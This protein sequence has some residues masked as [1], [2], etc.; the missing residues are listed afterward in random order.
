MPSIS[1]S[2]I[3]TLLFH[4]MVGIGDRCPVNQPKK[5][6][7]T[8]QMGVLLYVIAQMIII[9]SHLVL[10]LIIQCDMFE[11]NRIK[12]CGL[13][14][15]MIFKNK[16]IET[17]QEHFLLE[18]M[19]SL[20]QKPLPN[21]QKKLLII[22][23]V[24]GM[25]FFHSNLLFCYLQFLKIFRYLFFL[26]RRPEHGPM[27]VQLT[28]PVSRFKHIQ[29]LQHMCR[30]ESRFHHLLNYCFNI[31]FFFPRFVILKT[32]VR[33]DLIGTLPLPRRLLDYLNYKHY[34][35]EQIESD[36]SQSQVSLLF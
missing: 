1:Q 15:S 31:L 25:F 11:S 4:S 27:R 29:S 16:S 23:E 22:P 33:K 20:S 35:S 21:L 8:N 14:F 36:S 24:E 32:V 19:L 13:W 18:V 34:Y 2:K 26:H 17:F 9:F 3:T 6:Y 5:F 7:P 10:S 12:V 28:N 30:Y